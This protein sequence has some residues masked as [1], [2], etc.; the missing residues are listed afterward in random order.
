MKADQY[1]QNIP[2]TI[3]VTDEIS[4]YRSNQSLRKQMVSESEQH[5]PFT[6]VLCKPLGMSVCMHVMREVKVVRFM[7]E[8]SPEPPAGY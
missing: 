1:T 7:N 5:L 4:L 8:Q 6:V 3:G 2:L